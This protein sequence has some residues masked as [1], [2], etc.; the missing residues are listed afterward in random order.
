MSAIMMNGI[1]KNTILMSVILM[2]GIAMS[3]IVKNVSMMNF[4][5][6]NDTDGGNRRF[7]DFII[8]IAFVSSCAVHICV[9]VIVIYLFTKKQA[10][11]MKGTTVL[12]PPF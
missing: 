12:S 3:S 5:M 1:L 9:C 4:T 8:L 11:L 2:T 7:D 6:I 10:T